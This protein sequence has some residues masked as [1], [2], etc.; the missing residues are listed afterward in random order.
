VT[1]TVESGSLNMAQGTVIFTFNGDVKLAVARDVL[2]ETINAPEGNVN[3]NAGGVVS[4]RLRDKAAFFARALKIVAGGSISLLTDVDSLEAMSSGSV[5]VQEQDEL[6]LIKVAGTVIHLMSGGSL[7]GGSIEASSNVFVVSGGSITGVSIAAKADL[8]LRAAGS[9]SGSITGGNL[10][11]SAGSTIDVATHVTRMTPP[12][13]HGYSAVPAVLIPSPAPPAAHGYS[14]MPDGL[15]AKQPASSQSGSTTPFSPDI[16]TYS[17]NV[18]ISKEISSGSF[19]GKL[20]QSQTAEIGIAPR[21]ISAFCPDNSVGTIA[22]HSLR[23]ADW[24]SLNGTVSA[25]FHHGARLLSLIELW[26]VDLL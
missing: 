19:E 13:A 23:K 17:S 5:S 8:E 7:N 1:I 16:R 6:T 25:W 9:M 18:T 22:C 24:Q 12:V 15:S 10:K 11:I 26:K 21:G 20:E 4:S 3:V 2:L 14:M